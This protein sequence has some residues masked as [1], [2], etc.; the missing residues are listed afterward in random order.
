MFKF[1]FETFNAEIVYFHFHTFTYFFQKL[2]PG[3]KP[4]E[5]RLC[6]LKFT[7]ASN[8]AKHIRNI[9][10]KEKPHK[11]KRAFFKNNNKLI[12]LLWK[13]LKQCEQ[14]GRAFF[15]RESLRMHSVTHTGLKPFTCPK[16]DCLAAFGWYRK[17]KK[18]VLKEHVNENIPIPTEKS[19]FE[20][21][22]MHLN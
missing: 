19:Y 9:H 2:C 20:Q 16:K 21:L 6:S 10:E 4:Y 8:M 15:S 1:H 17:L 5:C 22:Q 18:H 14:C 3:I 12:I 13:S 11:V 7:T